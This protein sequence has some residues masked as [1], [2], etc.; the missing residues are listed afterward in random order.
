M[1]ETLTPGQPTLQNNQNIPAGQA[2]SP[3]T[4]PTQGPSITTPSTAIPDKPV[5]NY[6]IAGMIQKSLNQQDELVK[7]VS[8]FYTP[9]EQEVTAQKN[10]NDSVNALGNFDVSL[11]GGLQKIMQKPIALEFQQGQQAALTRDAAFTRS[12]LASAVDANTRVLQSAQTTRTQK[13]E[14]AKFL[15]DANRNSLTDTIQL[16]KAT[17]PE[18]IATTVDPY[19]GKMT[20][21]MKNPVT[22]ETYNKDLGVVQ[23]PQKVQN[24][25]KFAQ[26]NAV[27]KPFFT[28]DGRTIINSNTGEEY[29]TPEQY[30]AAGG[31]NFTDVEDLS[32]ATLLQRK[33]VVALGDAYKDAGIL[34]TDDMQTALAKLQN[35]P[36]YAVA[37]AGKYL[38]IEK[39]DP[40]TGITTTTYI[41]PVNGSVINSN[42]LSQGGF[43]GQPGTMRTD[44][45]NNP[46]AMTTDVARSLGLIEGVDYVQGDKFPGDSKLYTAKLLGNPVETTIKALDTAAQAGKGAFL[47]QSGKPRWS[48]ISM[49]DKEWLAKSPMEK[50]QVITDMYKHEGGSGELVQSLTSDDVKATFNQAFAAAAANGSIP[51]QQRQYNYRQ[52]QTA[53]QQGDVDQARNILIGTAMA[54][55]PA[56][57]KNQAIGRAD[58]LASITAI[59]KY[60]KEYQ[61]A[62]GDTN[63]L[64]G[65]E[66]QIANK[67]GTTIGYDQAFINSQILSA[68]FKYRRSMS[69]V[70]FGK[71]ESA[72]YQKL[73]PGLGKTGKFNTAVIDGF[74]QSIS[75]ATEAVL[76]SVMGKQNY[77]AIF[78]VGA[79]Q[80]DALTAHIQSLSGEEQTINDIETLLQQQDTSGSM[81]K[82]QG[83]LQTPAQ[84]LGI[85]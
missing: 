85:Y 16:M 1:N 74:K 79:E 27:S 54:T 57:Q 22:G 78:G 65:T 63:L 66:Q 50:R 13:L 59:D 80:M 37:T 72:D 81:N 55:Q 51:A 12:S 38:K 3:W 83:L 33:S 75:L 17:A 39:T 42:G 19:S 45:N 4:A 73:F 53:L 70:A 68:F 60:L 25:L 11:E 32:G 84:R 34:P 46:T 62:G 24:N 35:S 41:N 30:Y 2:G 15:Y 82:V 64:V 29:S 36:L 47:T 8:A 6:D 48:Y 58:A 52:L 28:R 10:L 76:G 7:N 67:L 20:V 49:S 69:G 61:A 18:N 43:T 56:D 71:E 31:K 40:D 44:R 5:G 14:A 26:E 21:T 23:T 77:D 9:T